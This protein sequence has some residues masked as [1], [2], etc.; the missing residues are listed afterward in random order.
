ML[1]T[2]S[3]E[4]GV[5]VRDHSQ[6]LPREK[7]INTVEYLIMHDN[8]FSAFWLRSSVVSALISL[9]MHNQLFSLEKLSGVPAAPASEE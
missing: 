2:G 3:S 6:L 4:A 5:C 8:H 9:I 7:E 1:V